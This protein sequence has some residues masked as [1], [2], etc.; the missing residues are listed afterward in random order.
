VL[1][2]VMLKMTYARVAEFR[3]PD[4]HRMSRLGGLARM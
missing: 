2:L 1:L 3:L 4:R